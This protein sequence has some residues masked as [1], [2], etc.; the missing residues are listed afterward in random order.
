MQKMT[1]FNVNLCESSQMNGMRGGKSLKAKDQN[2]KHKIFF[3]LSNPL[4]DFKQNF[5]SCERT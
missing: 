5:F 1:R 3:Y 4:V 2:R